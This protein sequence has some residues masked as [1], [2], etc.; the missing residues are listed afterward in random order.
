MQRAMTK[1]KYLILIT[2]LFTLF[3]CEDDFDKYEK[4][5]WL[6]GL[7]F[8]RME[9]IDNLQTFTKCVEL[10]GYDKVIDVSGSY[11][12]F[13]PS[14]EA[15]EQ[16][17]KSHPEYNS[18]E[19]IPQDELLELVKIHV[20]QNAWGREQLR[21]LDV[22]G[23][24]DPTDEFNNK[25]W[26][27]KRQTVLVRDDYRFGL[28]RDKNAYKKWIIVDSTETR[29]TRRFINDGRKYVPIF[30]SEYF[31]LN[32]LPL[33]DFSFYFDRNF[34]NPDD[35]YF[36]DSKVGEQF[37]AD[38][39]F[40]YV[41]DKVV[42]PLLNAYEILSNEED[43]HD[44]SEFLRLVNQFPEIEYN[45]EETFNQPG[46]DEGLQID[47]L[48][49]LSYPDL[50]FDI[51]D[52]ETRAPA[53]GIGLPENVTIRFQNGLLAPTNDAFNKFLDEYVK[54]QEQWG[55]LEQMPRR[56]KKIIANSYMSTSP[57]Y[58]SD[59]Q[60]GFYNGEEDI[61]YLEPSAIVEKQFGS[62]ATFIGV[63]EPIVPRAFSSVTGP[64]YR[65]RTFST[66]MN[67]IE[68]TGLTS[69]L[70][71]PESDYAFFVIQDYQLEHDSTMFYKK[72]ENDKGVT[73]TFTG[74]ERGQNPRDQEF[75]TQDLRLMLMNQVAI[76]TPK[77][78]ARKEF[79][80]TLGGNHLIWDNTTYTV[81]GT[82]YS[83]AG[84]ISS[85]MVIVQP[86]L[87]S[88][89]ADNGKTYET[90]AL[91]KFSGTTL[92]SEIQMASPTFIDLCVEAGIANDRDG[93]FDFLSNID[94]AT[95]FLPSEASLNESLDS[96]R[97]LPTN[98]L[99]RFLK[100]HFF[101]GEDLIF[102]D[103]KLSEGYYPSAATFENGKNIEVY[104]KPG[105]DRIDVLAN[106]GSNYL[107]IQELPGVTN[108]ITSRRLGNDEGIH[109]YFR[110]TS[111]VVHF[112]DKAFHINE[113]DYK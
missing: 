82:S 101:K 42:E 41:V 2:L 44:Y 39:G 5:E 91:F 78:T 7:L 63:N 106:D 77:G 68:Y 100:L 46:A 52:E 24:I 10:S 31:N 34:E 113:I 65:R 99:E 89:N 15:F 93:T 74:W 90:N 70:K 13:A 69:A 104:L 19:D 58:E 11:T 107:T 98:E 92:F 43:E 35:I 22:N 1:G 48:F 94:L 85:E 45:E 14:D 66:F 87:I 59:L 75:S 112:M 83:V 86:K 6:E 60:N 47:S 38:N 53:G 21:M 110:V 61:I 88:N 109:F 17:F 4:P 81:R 18:V 37:F 30:Y 49:D 64:V 12:V 79:L 56:I 73:E 55:T 28:V 40:I 36:V 80:E 84:Y 25:P 105:A 3:S 23:W 27:F 51:T 72:V 54:G 50:A 57:I 9:T 95:V 20:V 8:T 62:N 111:G 32:N 96:L 67:I 102:T 71:R 26:G 29:F 16:Y 108:N 103:G 33:N 76:E 97:N